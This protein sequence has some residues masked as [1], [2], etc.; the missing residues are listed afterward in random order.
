MSQSKSKPVALI[1]GGA[2]GLGRAISGALLQQ[3]WQVMI[4]DLDGEAGTECLHLFDHLGPV[5][6]EAVD[7]AQ[8][9]QVKALMQTTAER[10]GQVQLLVNCAGISNPFSGALEDLDLATWQR[11]IDVNLTGTF[12]CVKHAAPMLRATRGSIINLASTRALQSEPDTEAYSASKGGVVSLTHA[13][14]IS[15]G[16]EV[17]VNAISPGWIEV[18]EWQKSSSR[19]QPF[20][21]QEDHEQHPVGR[22]GKPDDVAGLVLWLASDLA[23]FVTG[24]NFVLDGGMTRKMI[25]QAD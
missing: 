17:R 8:E 3:G 9:A 21:S 20:H 5:A 23:S 1:T 6:F 22:I 24:Q 15:L 11:Y 25:Y 2:Q 4:A 12:L 14:A 16:P 19:Y 7:V 13:L 18:G 10:L